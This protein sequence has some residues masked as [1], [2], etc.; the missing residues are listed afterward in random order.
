MCTHIQMCSALL[1]LETSVWLLKS[2]SHLVD[3]DP[4]FEFH[5]PCA[6]PSLSTL[7]C[8]CDKHLPERNN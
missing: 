6:L 3:Q 4:C 2:A 8:H 1:D 7:L 5:P